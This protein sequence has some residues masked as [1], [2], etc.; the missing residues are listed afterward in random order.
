MPF[1]SKDEETRINETF[2]YI[3]NKVPG[4]ERNTVT[5]FL[6]NWLS[7]TWGDRGAFSEGLSTRHENNVGDKNTRAA[8]RALVILNSNLLNPANPLYRTAQQVMT[9]PIGQVG[10]ALDALLPNFRIY[11]Q[12]EERVNTALQLKLNSLLANPEGFLNQYVVVTQSSAGVAGIGAAQDHQFYFY[13]KD[14]VFR[15]MPP[16]TGKPPGVTG[17]GLTVR[18]VNVPEMYWFDVPGRGDTPA[19]PP[20]PPVP[21]LTGTFDRLP[22]TELTGASLMVT[23]AFTGCSFCFKN[24]GGTVYGC[25]ISPDGTAA[26]RGP[27]IGAAPALATQLIASGNFAAPLAARA[28]NLKV[29]GR[30]LSAHIPAVAGNAGYTV[31]ALPGVPLTAASM[32]V[33]GVNVGGNWRLVAQENNG[34]IR[35]VT[36]LL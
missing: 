29:F 9:M 31:N 3:A 6:R 23:S 36:R 2:A 25:H 28:G 12:Q 18:A 24:V 32:Y 27:S 22:A 17:D 19:A 8:R 7:R 5:Q 11:A 21:P 15:C 1:W 34:G 16:G 26:N 14:Q 30:S 33:F 20:P 10:P 4:N 35:T 13:Y